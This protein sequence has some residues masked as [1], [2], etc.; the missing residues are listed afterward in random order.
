MSLIASFWLGERDDGSATSEC[1]AFHGCCHQAALPV[2]W[3]DSA[4]TPSG[5]HSLSLFSVCQPS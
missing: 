3:Y 4:R 5:G 1:G 2:H